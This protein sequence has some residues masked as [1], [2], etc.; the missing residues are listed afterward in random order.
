MFKLLVFFLEYPA[1]EAICGRPTGLAFDTIGDNLIISDAYYGI[2]EFDLKN[3]GYS[4]KQLVSPTEKIGGVVPRPAKLFNSVTV[5]KNG[6]IYWTDSTS[7]FDIQ[8]AA[9]A[10]LVNPS[11]RLVHY[12]RETK[13]NTVLIDQIFFAF[14]VALSPD[15]SFVIVAETAASRILKYFLKGEKKGTTEI[16][17]DGLPGIPDK[18]TADNDGMWIA[19]ISSADAKHPQPAHYLAQVPYVRK[20]LVRIVC[21]IEKAVR[22]FDVYKSRDVQ[23]FRWLAPT[24]NTIIRVDWNGNVVSAM[25]GFDGTAHTISNV[26]EFKDYLYLGSPFNDF[27]GRVKFTNKEK[28]SSKMIKN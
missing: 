8:D 19:L 27:I 17:V 5:A 22:F 20:F 9:N 25:H 24:R 14:G 7:D 23:A 28:Y 16:F 11:G 10:I 2:W 26:L 6:D 3:E 21:L 4:K 18:I 13:I 1:Q 15:E 12:N